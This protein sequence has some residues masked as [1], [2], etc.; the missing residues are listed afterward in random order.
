MLSV[1]KHKHWLHCTL[2]QTSLSFSTAAKDVTSTAGWLWTVLLNTSFG[3]YRHMS[4][5]LY[6]RI[7]LAV[8]YIFSTAGYVSSLEPMPTNWLLCP[9]NSTIEVSMGFILGRNASLAWS[10]RLNSSNFSSAKI[11]DGNS[12][13]ALGCGLLTASP[14]WCLRVLTEMPVWCHFVLCD[15]DKWTG[16]AVMKSASVGNLMCSAAWGLADLRRSK[17]CFL[18]DETRRGAA[19]LSV[20]SNR[21]WQD[22][23]V[24]DSPPNLPHSFRLRELNARSMLLER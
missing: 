6:P 8:L 1:R 7:L 9:G 12:S 2:G 3:P 22:K 21:A 20:D 15:R 4:S 5:R 16:S 10:L 13:S 24:D 11:S 17:R 19:S 23:S 14:S 18:N